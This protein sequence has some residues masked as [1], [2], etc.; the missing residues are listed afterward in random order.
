MK[1]LFRVDASSAMGIGHLMRCQALAQALA[2]QQVEI[3]F[4]LRQQ[5]VPLARGRHDWVGQVKSIPDH[6]S[7]PEELDWLQQQ[8]D[9]DEFDFVVLDGYQFDH[10]YRASLKA[11]F[12]YLVIF[13]DNN[14]SGPLYADMVINAASNA[15]KLNYSRTAP[16]AIYC[17]GTDYRILRQEFYSQPP[18]DWQQRH[19]LTLMLGG[20]DPLNLTLPIL[21]SLQKRKVDIPLRVITGAAYPYLDELQAFIQ[22]SAQPIQHIHNCQQMAEVVSY[23]RMMLS[24]A[25]GS[26]FEIAYCHTPALLVI[27]AENQRNATRQAA[28]Q[29]WCEVFDA[30]EKVDIELLTDKLLT[31]WHDDSQ[32]HNMHLQAELMSPANGAENV[33]DSLERMWR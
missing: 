5:T 22:Q 16:E 12:N 10:K 6:V 9:L 15:D 17:L 18:V 13:D 32:L 3:I 20:S 26:Q 27:V 29:G 28:Q 8:F 7:Q 1:V 30:T 31:V 24:A 25:G 11:A 21:Q 2:Q 33:L 4:A 23:S 14:D 19:S